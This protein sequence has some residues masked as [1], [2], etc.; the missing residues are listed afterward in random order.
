MNSRDA[1]ASKNFQAQQNEII[2][3][4]QC[5]ST[6]KASALDIVPYQLPLVLHPETLLHE[7][8]AVLEDHNVGK[9]ESVGEIVGKEPLPDVFF[10]LVFPE[11]KPDSSLSLSTTFDID[12]RFETS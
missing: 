8:D 7:D 6:P 11:E 2:T 3:Q 1:S 10:R 5:F 4:N 12:F 9:I